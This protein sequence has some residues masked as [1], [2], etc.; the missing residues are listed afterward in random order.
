M[1]RY[2]V[3]KTDDWA[4]VNANYKRSIK[5]FKTQKEAIVYA[6]ELIDTKTIIVQGDDYK[7]RKI[8][9]WDL[10][11]TKTKTVFVEKETKVIKYIPPYVFKNISEQMYK[12]KVKHIVL[13]SLLFVMA[14][15]AIVFGA[16]YIEE[17]V[18]YA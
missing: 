13:W 7:F 16:L 11:K 6:S 1:I 2:I 3:K 9:S 18:A 8:S 14:S 15:L 10:N 4:V 17:V 12:K 5:I